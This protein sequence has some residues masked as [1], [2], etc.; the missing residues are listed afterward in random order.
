MLKTSV[1]VGPDAIEGIRAEWQDLA[2]T[3]TTATPFQ[4]WE[5]QSTWLRH[6]RRSKRPHILTIREGNDLVGLMPLT[7]TIGPW[8]TIRAMGSGASD[9]LHPLAQTGSEEIVAFEVARHL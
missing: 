8:R 3:S 1:L 9:Y 2:K 7:R 4:T 6:F 5:W